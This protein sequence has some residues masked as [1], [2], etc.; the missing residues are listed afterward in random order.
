MT[1][2]CESGS[3]RCRSWNEVRSAPGSGGQTGLALGYIQSGKTTSITALIA[4]AADQGYQIIVALL[5]GTNLLLDQNKR[6]A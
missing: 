4:A 2:A 1:A 3:Q 6:Q 5:G